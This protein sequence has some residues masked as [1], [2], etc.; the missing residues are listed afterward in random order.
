MEWRSST[1]ARLTARA[2]TDGM[3]GETSMVAREDAML[4]LVRGAA[5]VAATMTMGLAAGLF[6]VFAYCVMP[7]LGRTDDRTFVGAMQSINVAILNGWFAL[8]FVGALVFTALAAVLHLRGE[9][10]PVLPWIAA[11]LVLYGA[12]LVVTFAANVPLN[13]ALDAAGAPDRI[14]DLAAVRERFEATWVRWNIARAVASAAAFG[15][16]TWALVVYGRGW[17]PGGA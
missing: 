1:M 3:G 12:V 14:A 11:A 6:Y 16:L 2:F 17:T 10:W 9:G 5:L 8:S 7:G 13:N 15:C 4:E